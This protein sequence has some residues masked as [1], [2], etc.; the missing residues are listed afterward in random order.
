[1]TGTHVVTADEA[2]ERADVVVARRAHA[3]RSAV[4]K[5]FTEARVLVNGRT[6]KPSTPVAA[7]DEIAFSVSLPAPL[8]L[9]AQAI[10]LDIVYEDAD[11]IVVDK[12]AGMVTHPAHGSRDGTLVNALLA[13]VGAL[14]AQP[15]RDDGEPEPAGVRPG[16]IHRLDRD[17]S[18]LIVVAK[19]P[20]ALSML[21]KAMQRRAIAREYLGLVAGIPEPDQGTIEGPIGRDPQHPLRFAVRSDGKPAVTQYAIRERLV[22]ASELVFRLETGRTHQI[23][24]HMAAFGYPILGDTVYGRRDSRLALTGQ[25]LHAWRLRLRHPRTG[26]SLEFETP[27]PSAYQQARD[28]LRT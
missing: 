12:P 4:T 28:A 20:H 18:G 14:P 6:V 19:T 13:H 1:M 10:P 16:L 8:E 25:A 23:R 15:K 24:V 17:T 9:R 22:R 21:G 7:G 5:A 2:G 27:P 11:L 3:S 26:E